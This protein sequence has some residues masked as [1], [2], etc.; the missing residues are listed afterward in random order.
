MILLQRVLI[1]LNLY[2]ILFKIYKLTFRY[3][4][5]AYVGQGQFLRVSFFEGTAN[6]NRLCVYVFRPKEV[7]YCSVVNFF[8]EKYIVKIC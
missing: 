2:M 7:L 5:V 4:T 1:M 6:F 8:P 3:L